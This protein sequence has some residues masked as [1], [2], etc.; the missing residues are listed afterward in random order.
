[1]GP[2]VNFRGQVLRA[3]VLPTLLSGVLSAVCFGLAVHL[4]SELD[5][6]VRADR[7]IAR[8][9]VTSASPGGREA[10][11]RS[12]LIAGPSDPLRAHREADARLV[13]GGPE[14]A[15]RLARPRGQGERWGPHAGEAIGLRAG[16][17]GRHRD[18]AGD[19]GGEG[20]MDA[21]RGSIAAFPESEAADRDRR[22]A[23]ILARSWSVLA[24]CSGAA[25]ALAVIIAHS[26]RRSLRVLLAS[27]QSALDD[28][29]AISDRQERENLN[30]L[31]MS[32]KY[33]AIFTL[34]SEGRI[35]SWN[36]AAERTLGY[37]ADDVLGR[38]ASCLYSPHDVTRDS[39]HH[40]LEWATREGWLEDDRWLIRKDGFRFRAR[41]ALMTIRDP[42]GGLCGYTKVVHEIED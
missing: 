16:P 39:L 13:S 10:A 2:A 5:R 31:S 22:N 6:V 11:P 42:G 41:V 19:A 9:D 32:M 21:T 30:L 35:A 15:G 28:L 1:M 26:S 37:R 14:Q 24:A 33:Y 38:Q 17:S 4:H 23:S 18:P 7:P 25:I 29:R 34:D 20:R 40:D 3:V 36:A 8:A 12:D 27:F